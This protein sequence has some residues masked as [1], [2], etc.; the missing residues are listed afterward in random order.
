MAGCTSCG[1]RA[2][3]VS[4]SPHSG[5]ND[6]WVLR[7]PDGSVMSFATETAARDANRKNG[8]NGLVRRA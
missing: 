7:L 6:S 4:Q 1:G 3:G 2:R 5:P 8:N